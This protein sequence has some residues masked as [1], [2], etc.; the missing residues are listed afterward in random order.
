[1]HNHDH[2][3]PSLNTHDQLHRYLF[4]KVSVR[5]EMVRLAETYQQML[6]NHDY[7][8]PVQRLLGE[9][10]VATSLLTATL[11]FE[12]TITV[13]L[14][15]DG[16][17]RLAVIN[18]DHLQK[19]RGVARVQGDISDEMTLRQM[20]GQGHLVITI[21]P[22]Q[23][24]RYQG[25][26]GLEGETLAECLE[27]YFAQSEQLPTRLFLLTGAH[28]GQP[29]AGGFLLQ[30]LPDE[31]ANG[32]EFE[33]LSQ[34]TSTMTADEMFGLEAEEVLYRLYH[35][36]EVTVYPAQAVCFSCTCSRER[37]GAAILTVDPLEIEQILSENGEID[38]HC[39]YCQA[40][41][42]FDAID[43]QALRNG[44]HT[45]SSNQLH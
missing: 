39:D 31:H 6:N 41:Y 1:M 9:M 10:L 42:R 18:G 27:G 19:L 45:N 22:N 11:K 4:D 21:T 26:V 36:E 12:G 29:V 15:G 32:D 37:S 28:Q 34:L 16:P 17:L 30:V 38:M 33:H 25:I 13:Q 2:T 43:I 40:H 23:G 35:Q 5:G 7:P 44:S 24:E 20:I 3:S 14:Q 8:L